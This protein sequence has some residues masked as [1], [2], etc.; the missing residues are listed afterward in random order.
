[1]EEDGGMENKVW[2]DGTKA[3][4]KLV[5][6]I[7]GTNTKYALMNG[8]ADILE[9]G[10][11]RTCY[12]SKEEYLKQMT[13]QAKAFG[14]VGGICVSTNGRMQPDGVT[15]R[16][17]TMNI[18]KGVNLQE[19]LSK[20]TGLPVSVLNDGFAA[21][22]GEW[23]YGSGKG[24]DNMMAVVLGTGMGAGLILNGSLYEGRRNNAAMVF[25]MLSSCGAESCDISG[26]ATSFVFLL[27]RFARTKQLPPQEMTGPEFFRCLEAGDPAASALF[28]E[29]TRSVAA[30]IYNSSLLLDLDRV[31]L[32]GGLAE[33][34]ILIRE[35]NQRLLEMVD[36]IAANPILSG[37]RV[38]YDETDVRVRVV[39]GELGAD[40]NLYGAFEYGRRPDSR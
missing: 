29:Y 34:D 36:Q 15:Y 18:L 7:G 6:D 26:M 40:A 37:G 21:A 39:K 8:A 2:K 27:L 38:L 28:R 11:F 9:K 20:Q 14:A 4:K 17:Y 23:R 25:G 30:V 1:M 13:D 19:E 12:A 5:F 10:S 35:V 22:V 31:I 32:T 16:A 33:R 3:D 24:L